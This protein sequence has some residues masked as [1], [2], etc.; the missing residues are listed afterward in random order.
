MLSAAHQH[1][2]TPPPCSV[3]LAGQPGVIIFTRTW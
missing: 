1:V 2:H 3:Q